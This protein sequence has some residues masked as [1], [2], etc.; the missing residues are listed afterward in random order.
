[1]A[2]C[3]QHHAGTLEKNGVFEEG[4]LFANLPLNPKFQRIHF[5]SNKALWRHAAY[6]LSMTFFHAMASSSTHGSL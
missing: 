1:M 4:E 5:D 3:R 6:F 2:T